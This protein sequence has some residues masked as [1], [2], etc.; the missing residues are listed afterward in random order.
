MSAE[1]VLFVPKAEKG[2]Q[3]NLKQFIGLCRNELTAYG[4]DLDFDVDEWD[5]S[6]HVQ[7]K[8]MGNKRTRL[9]FYTQPSL[10]PVSYTHLTL[11]TIL[12]V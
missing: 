5:I 1:L 11:P 7:L 2:A 4:R 12:L 3:E 10:T 9:R 8:G 6:A